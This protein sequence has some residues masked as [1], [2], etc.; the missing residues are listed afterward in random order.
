MTELKFVGLIPNNSNYEDAN[1][2]YGYCGSTDF[3]LNP[4]APSNETLAACSAKY[5]TASSQPDVYG[6]Y[7]NETFSNECAGTSNCAFTMTKYVDYNID[8]PAER[9][10]HNGTNACLTNPAKVYMQYFCVQTRG[11]L[12]NKREQGLFISCAASFS[13]VVFLVVV[14]Y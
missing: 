9:Y 13:A 7:L 3:T 4:S 14:W 5:L 6:T 11:E 12:N 1:M 10:I 2:P 8:D